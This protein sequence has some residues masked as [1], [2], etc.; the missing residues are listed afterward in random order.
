MHT[1]Y[2]LRGCRAWKL[3]LRRLVKAGAE[4]NLFAPSLLA[5]YQGGSS[6][7]D[8]VAAYALSRVVEMRGDARA[9]IARE[10]MI[11]KPLSV[12]QRMLGEEEALRLNQAIDQMYISRLGVAPVLDKHPIGG[13]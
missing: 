7:G 12:P 9:G 3:S 6:K 5:S 2:W 10:L 13:R 1:P 11:A 4:G 8:P